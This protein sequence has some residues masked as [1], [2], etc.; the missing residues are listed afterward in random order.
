[1]MRADLQRRERA[2]LAQRE[3]GRA[4]RDRARP[5]RA[6][7]SPSAFARPASGSTTRPS[8]AS[9]KTT[10]GHPYATQELCYFTWEAA[11]PGETADAAPRS[12]RARRRPALRARALLARLGRRVGADSG[13]CSRRSRPSPD[14][15]TA[16]TTAAATA[17]RRRRTCRRRWPRSRGA[18]S[19][20][21]ARTAPTRSSSRS[22]R[23]GSRGRS[24][25]PASA[26][27]S[28][29]AISAAARAAPSV[30]TG[31]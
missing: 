15:R 4:R 2:V 18:S 25:A 1:M 31:R 7:S 20:R 28:S 5:L 27:Q 10:A 30:S 11:D 3:A 13:S 8:T 23:S 26:D 14:A 16:R 12:R 17:C 19:S 9:S 24:R 21:S 6:A 22:S 29:S